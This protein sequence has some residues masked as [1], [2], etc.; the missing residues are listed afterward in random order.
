ML[1]TCS[2]C[3]RHIRSTEAEC[4]FCHAPSEDQHRP[5]R[6]HLTAAVVIGAA[7]SLSS[8]VR[9]EQRTKYGAPPPINPTTNTSEPVTQPVSNPVRE[10]EIV[11][12]Y[13]APPIPIDDRPKPMYGLPPAP[14]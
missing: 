2:R 11:P 9:E 14:K 13:G 7:L 1:V 12:A 4:P 3:Q 10:P 5:A 8:C 6:A